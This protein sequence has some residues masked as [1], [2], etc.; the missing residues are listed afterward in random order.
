MPRQLT[1]ADIL[2]TQIDGKEYVYIKPEIGDF[3]ATRTIR[4]VSYEGQQ[5][6]NSSGRVVLKGGD[7]LIENLEVENQSRGISINKD[8]NAR[9][10]DY[11]F[12]GTPNSGDGKS[13]IYRSETSSGLVEIV[14][15]YADGRDESGSGNTD[16]ISENLNGGGGRTWIRDFTAKNFLDA[17]VDVKSDTVLANATLS[18]A[19]TGLKVWNAEL[20]IVNSDVSA[21]RFVIQLMHPDA[22]VYFYNTIFN[23]KSAPSLAEVQ[24]VGSFNVPQSR[25]ITN[26]VRLDDNPLPEIDDFFQFDDARYKAQV[27]VDGGKWIDVALPNGG[28]LGSHVGDTLASLPIQDGGSYQVRA[29]TEENGVKSPI[30]TASYVLKN[31]DYERGALSAGADPQSGPSGSVRGDPSPIALFEAMDGYN[32]I[33]K[34]RPIKGGGEHLVGTRQADFIV[35]TSGDDLIESNRSG[36]STDLIFFDNRTDIGDDSFVDF[37]RTRDKL[38]FTEFVDLG[39]DRVHRLDKFGR[40][41]LDDPSLDANGGSITLAAGLANRFIHFAGETQE[42]LFLYEIWNRP[43]S[44]IG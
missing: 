1:N 7:T 26:I 22:K 29:W 28:F 17:S 44:E 38:L 11:E 18:G 5:Q 36:K 35:T 20:T 27:S 34:G 12:Y 16:A 2:V 42:G 41:D 23:G 8:A 31:G 33:T 15:W 6:F 14:R 37:S 21:D 3:S 9:I 19:R 4:N 10:Y 43:W 24:A 13:S 40:F 32:L 30:A 25:K 39:R